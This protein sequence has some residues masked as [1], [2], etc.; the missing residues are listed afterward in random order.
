MFCAVW[1]QGFWCEDW[2]PYEC[3]R[4]FP[5]SVLAISPSIR[6][7]VGGQCGTGTPVCSVA[8]TI[9]SGV[10]SAPPLLE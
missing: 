8:V 7:V 4:V 2:F 5:E 6:G 9:L 10:G 1:I 3:C